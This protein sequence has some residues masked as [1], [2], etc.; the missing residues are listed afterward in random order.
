MNKNQVKNSSYYDLEYDKNGRWMSYWYQISEVSRLRPNSILVVGIGNGLV[1]SYLKR[2]YKNVVTID[3][4]KSLAPDYVGDILYFK[5][6]KRFDVV[7]CA[8]TLE[9]LPFSQFKKAIGK[10]YELTNKFAVISL[11][12]R[13]INASFIIR[14]PFN[15]KLNLVL[16]LPL[17]K[18]FPIGKDHYWEIGWRKCS[19]PR[20]LGDFQKTGFIVLKTFLVPEKPYHRFFILE[21]KVR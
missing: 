21:K 13:G 18:K 14:L 11:P 1:N 5:S 10:I 19:L 9:H 6:R 7:L 12:H 3:I 2:L 8:E 15:L 16:K 17:S 4:D 20:I